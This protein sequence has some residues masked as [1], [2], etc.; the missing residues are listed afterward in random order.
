MKSFTAIAIATLALASHASAQVLSFSQPV[1]A[2]MWTA[3]SK[4]T[5]SWTNT[6][7]DITGNTTFPIYLNEQ[8]GAYQV[9][10]SNTSAIGTLDC[11]K[12][13]S[14]TVNVP[15]VPQGSAYSILVTD[16][17]N[18]SYSA[19]F[20]INSSIPAASTTAATTTITTTTAAATTIANATSTASLSTVTANA[21]T[22]AASKPTSTSNAGALKAGSSVALVIVAAVASLML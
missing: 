13:G 12:A 15:M 7:S 22:T 18:Q 16:G 11:S 17:G 8:V 1:S 19:Q 21:T 14:T 6:C 20:V 3:G 5:V 2:T 4:A 10:V 9:Q